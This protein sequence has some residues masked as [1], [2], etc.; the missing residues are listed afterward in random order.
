M[1]AVLRQDYARERMVFLS[2][3]GR[4]ARGVCVCEQAGGGG[5]GGGCRAFSITLHY[6]CTI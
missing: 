6:S 5:G 3:T 2:A 1:Q 4:H